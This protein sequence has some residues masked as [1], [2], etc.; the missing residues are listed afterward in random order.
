MQSKF[1][2]LENSPQKDH[3]QNNAIFAYNMDK[4]RPQM[5]SQNWKTK[6][7]WLEISTNYRD[8]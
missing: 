5:I 3:P 7:V 1:W 2:D 6:S 8:Q 4:R